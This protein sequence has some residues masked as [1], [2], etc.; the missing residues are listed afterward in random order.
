MH[1]EI[2][3]DKLNNL[4]KMTQLHSNIHH[5]SSKS[6]TSTNLIYHF[7]SHISSEPFCLACHRLA[8]AHLPSVGTSHY[9]YPDHLV[10]PKPSV[11]KNLLLS[12]CPATSYFMN[13]CLYEDQHET[14]LDF[15]YN[16]SYIETQW[17]TMERSWRLGKFLKEMLQD[18]SQGPGTSSI[19]R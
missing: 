2:E 4:L 13:R 17:K 8:M 15:L 5:K 19:I 1:E 11:P 3:A 12:N 18:S 14:R 6:M 16:M 7:F 9:S 10:N